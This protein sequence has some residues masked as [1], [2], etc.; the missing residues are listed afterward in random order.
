MIEHPNATADTTPP[1][2]AGRALAQRLA[3]DSIADGDATGWFETLYAAAEQG[4]ATVPWAGLAPNPRLVSALAGFTGGG[5]RAL[6]IGCGLGDDAEHVA[7]LNFTTVAFDVSPTA[8][9]GARRRFPRSSV[10]YLTA[11]LL[12]PPQMWTGGFDLVVEVFTLQ[13]LTG[14]ARRAAFAR[15]AQLVAPGGRLLVIAGA[16]D[17]HEAPGQ[18][19]W[20]L[21]RAEIGSFRAYGLSED[22]V[23]DFIDVEERGRIRRW[24]AWFTAPDRADQEESD[25]V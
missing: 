7:S 5:R 21:T 23:V 11:D 22:S 10:E 13:V 9:A 24:R 20:P 17:E 18:M 8:I 25:P 2:D 1:A 15:T 4:T 16:R 19:P 3:A 6:V 14:A 12:S